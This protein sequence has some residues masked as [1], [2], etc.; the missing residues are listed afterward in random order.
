MIA[1]ILVLALVGVLVYAITTLAPMPPEF[2]RL[3]VIVA[4]IACILYCL[5]AFGVIGSMPVPRVQ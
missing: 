3:I 1:L 2:K 5:A 4:V